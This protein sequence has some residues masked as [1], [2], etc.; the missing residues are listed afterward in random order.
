[1]TSTEAPTGPGGAATG[2]ASPF[3]ALGLRLHGRPCLVVGGGRVAARKAGLLLKAGALV[4]V[5][6]PSLGPELAGLH[7]AGRLAGW[8]VRRFDEGDVA[9]RLLA[10]AATDDAA[11][12]SAVAAACRARGVLVN[13]V[14]AP[15]L[16]DFVVP[17]GVRRGP[18]HLAVS[19]SGLAPA[20]AAHI[21]RR[22]G[23]LYPEEWGSV[24]DVLGDERR[25]AQTAGL[26]E[27]ARRR[28]AQELAALDFESLLIDGGLELVREA[29]AACAA[30][31]VE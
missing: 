4:A 10:V 28:F 9:G 14:D 26:D 12:N 11:V 3:L 23:E 31:Y 17:A 25:R 21:A 30:R 22:L 27:A 15:D 20:L 16:S 29:V 18:L 8:E 5:V 7:A 13:V 24:V 1:M 6:A 2:S 19:T